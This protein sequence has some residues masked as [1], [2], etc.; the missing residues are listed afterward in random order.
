VPTT[1]AWIDVALITTSAVLVGVAASFRLGRLRL[2]AAVAIV[3]TTAVGLYL[4]SV[5]TWRIHAPV[6]AGNL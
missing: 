4:L 6:G 1:Q 3:V 5:I 2:L